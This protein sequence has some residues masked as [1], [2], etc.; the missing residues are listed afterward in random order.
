MIRRLLRR[1][2]DRV[3]LLHNWRRRLSSQS[4]VG[5]ALIR[6]S[7]LGPIELTDGERELTSVLAQPKRLA[8]LAY[9]TI[10]SGGFQ[11]RDSLRALFWPELDDA[12]AR[13]SVL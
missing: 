13:N 10:A 11:R 8:L 12:H 7:V 9:L 3:G 1:M 6:L 5:G 2:A 4:A